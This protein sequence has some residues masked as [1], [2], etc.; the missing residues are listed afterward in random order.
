MESFKALEQRL[1]NPMIYDGLFQ[2]LLEIH[3]SEKTPIKN[4]R[5]IR[6]FPLVFIGLGLALSL[7]GVA[8]IPE[9]SPIASA[10]SASIPI[11]AS[12][13]LLLFI[14]LILV[15]IFYLRRRKKK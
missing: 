5:I 8:L 12:G 6:K 11:C 14:G 15:W 1:S 10:S 4:R 2:V 9:F 7:L 13:L 3:T